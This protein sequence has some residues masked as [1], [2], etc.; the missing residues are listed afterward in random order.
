MRLGDNGTCGIVSQ[1][2]EAVAAEVK[3]LEVGHEVEAKVNAICD[4]AWRLEDRLDAIDA[5]GYHVRLV[6]DND[7]GTYREVREMVRRHLAASNPC[8]FCGGDNT[9]GAGLVGENTE[10]SNCGPA[11]TVKRYPHQ[12]GEQLK[13]C[14]EELAELE[15]FSIGVTLAREVLSTALAWADWDDLARVFMSEFEDGNNQA[16]A[17]ERG[18][19]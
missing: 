11:G 13:D 14:A 15:G 10:C 7:E 18:T 9:A 8:P 5:I 1:L 2:G 12:L 17:V 6:L 3:S 16:A 4:R 19:A